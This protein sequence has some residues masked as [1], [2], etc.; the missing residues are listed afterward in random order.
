MTALETITPP[1]EEEDYTVSSADESL[2]QNAIVTSSDSQLCGG[3]ERQKKHRG[4]RWRTVL[5]TVLSMILVFLLLLCRLYD[6]SDFVKRLDSAGGLLTTSGD[7]KSNSVHDFCTGIHHRQYI[8]HIPRVYPT[9]FKLYAADNVVEQLTT[10]LSD[11]V[12]LPPQQMPPLPQH[13]P[14]TK[15]GLLHFIVHTVKVCWKELVTELSLK[16]LKKS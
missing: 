15:H 2:E 5:M 14:P 6:L 7:W 9:V 16:D 11:V 3:E 10:G 4:S 12:P 8:P 13:T 1:T